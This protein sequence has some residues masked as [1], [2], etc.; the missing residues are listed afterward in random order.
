MIKGEHIFH[1]S[2]SHSTNKVNVMSTF[3]AWFNK[4]YKRWSRSQPGEEDFLAFCDQLGYSTA[5]VLEWFHGE[6]LPEGSE[7]L[8][9]AGVLGLIVYEVLDLQKPDPELI[10]IFHSFS[11]LTGDYRSKL[12][13]ALWEA[14]AEMLRKG[15]IVHSEESKLI[16]SQAFKKWG[17]ESPNH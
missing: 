14:H 17:F 16:L 9:I 6:S 7:V 1:Y 12:A 5:K 13:H 11:H 10:K 4:A 2:D 8:S 15:I 3:P